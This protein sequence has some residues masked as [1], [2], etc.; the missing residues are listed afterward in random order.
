MKKEVIDKLKSV[1]IKIG[2]LFFKYRSI[3]PVPWIALVFTFLFKRRLLYDVEIADISL[4][5]TICSIAFLIASFVIIFGFFIRFVVVLKA[6]KGTSGRRS[7]FEAKELVTTGCYRYIRHPLYFSNFL[8]CF[9][10]SI[11]TYQFSIICFTILLF[12]IE[13]IPI[14]YAEENFLKN[15]YPSSYSKWSF[16]VPVFFPKMKFYK[17]LVAE[18][19]N[20]IMLNPK[21]IFEIPMKEADGIFAVIFITIFLQ[22]GF[23]LSKSLLEILFLEFLF[24]LLYLLIKI[25]KKLSKSYKKTK[26]N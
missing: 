5:N 16:V 11:M 18:I 10:V 17:Y 3:L 12:A 19:Y 6:P 8:I 15:R 23:L 2:G 14:I 21:V 9:G 25:S 1:I 20:A 26:R 4:R 13:Y 24:F 22:Y 7:Y